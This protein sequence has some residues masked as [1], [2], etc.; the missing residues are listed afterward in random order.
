LNEVVEGM[1]N[2][3]V[4]LIGEN[5]ELKLKLDSGLG[6]VKIDPVQAQQILLNLVLNARDALPCGGHIVEIKT[7][8]ALPHRTTK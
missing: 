3:L 5:I 8:V 6:L 1:R 4:R 7:K 2:L